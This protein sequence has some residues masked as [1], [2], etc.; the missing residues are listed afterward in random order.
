MDAI[1][2]VLTNESHTV[3]I[4]NSG[5]VHELE[6]ANARTNVLAYKGIREVTPVLS[7]GECVGCDIKFVQNTAQ[8]ISLDNSFSTATANINVT[9]DG[10]TVVKTWTISKAKQGSNGAT[11]A[12]GSSYIL[13]ITEGTRSFTY[14]QINLDPRP[15]TSTTFVGTLY[16][17]GNEIVEGVS[18][19]WVANGHLEGSSIKNTFTPTIKSIFDESILNNDVQLAVSYKGMTITQTVPVAITKDAN[20]LDWV[21]EWDDTKTDVRG[22]LILTPKLFAGSYDQEND[23]VTGVAIG[24]DVLNNGT[25][26]GVAGYQNNKTTFLLDTDG[27]FMVGNPF[28]EGSTG[29]YFDGDSFT[30]KVN[31]LSIE[32]ASVPTTDDLTSAIDREVNSAKEEVKAEISQVV[33]QVVDLDSYMNNALKDGILDE[34]ERAHL[35]TLYE[36]ISSE[37]IDVVSQHR[38]VA[39]NPYFTDEAIQAVL[40][41]RFDA[42]MACYRLY[43]FICKVWIVC[44]ASVL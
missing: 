23:L 7:K 43:C 32:G 41:E 27:T 39:N 16:E 8:L 14:S 18:Y 40:T 34:V 44:H 31:Q 4:D 21:Q 13:N 26:I 25:T 22:N 36:N 15:A 12:D 19:Y 35:D 11:G 42:Y 30:L 5:E 20:G 24:K 38:S 3:A 33:S 6:I 29:M 2:V 28:E 37:V 10:V 17:N 1:T 9:V